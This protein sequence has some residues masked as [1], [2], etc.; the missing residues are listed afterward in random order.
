MVKVG[1]TATFSGNVF[2]AYLADNSVLF[3]VFLVKSALLPNDGSDAVFL[4]NQHIRLYFNYT[5]SLRSAPDKNTHVCR[6][7]LDGWESVLCAVK[8]AL[9]ESER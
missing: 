3:N 9:E 5:H 1:G 8:G 6:S 7:F 2:G 4:Q